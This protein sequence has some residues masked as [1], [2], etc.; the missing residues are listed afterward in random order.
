MS[1]ATRAL[2][3][4]L[5]HGIVHA[6]DRH[7]FSFG[8]EAALR[9]PSGAD[10]SFA[11]IGYT[12]LQEH[13]LAVAAQ[14]YSRFG[15]RAGENVLLVCPDTC[16]G[17]Q[18]AAILGCMRIGAVFVPVDVSWLATT[19]LRFIVE[20]TRAKVAVVV[21]A[22]DADPEVEALAKEGVHKVVYVQPSG[23]R[24]CCLVSLVCCEEG[25]GCVEFSWL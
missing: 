13:S 4:D 14:L 21:A 17:A 22:V 1:R 7:C 19:K 10:G 5:Q 8:D 3:S 2:P 9:I 6:F 20:D 25:L 24:T 12:E 16:A 11:E 18:I 15:A 23:E